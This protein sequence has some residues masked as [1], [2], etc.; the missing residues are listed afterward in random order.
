MRAAERE[1]V[2]REALGIREMMG[3]AARVPNAIHLEI[4][5]PDWDPPAVAREAAV[6]AVHDRMTYTP[7]L[8]IPELRERIAARTAE[9]TGLPVDADMV[10]VTPGAVCAVT[11]LAVLRSGPDRPLLIA[12]PS[13]PNY[14]LTS[15]VAGARLVRYPLAGHLPDVDFL[16][17]LELDDAVL[18]LNSPANPTGAIIDRPLLVRLLELARSRGWFVLV[19]EVYEDLIWEG[20]LARAASVAGS[21]EGLAVVSGVSKS[22]GMTGY[23][24]GWLVT[25]PG[26]T[27]RADQVLETMV[28]CATGSS[29]AAS[30][31][32]LDAAPG[33]LD[34][35]RARLA[36][37]ASAITASCG[38]AGILPYA[39]RGGL[40]AWLS[41]GEE[42]GR[43]RSFA[44]D[45]LAAEGVAVAPGST[46]GPGGEG[47]VRIALVHPPEVLEREAERLV[48]FWSDYR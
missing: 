44:F 2:V 38:G 10:A 30:L 37:R 29:Q 15:A 27:R 31:A 14:A 23:R 18:I 9:R 36:E 6:R 32:A 40:Y 7:S 19:D 41:L 42:V 8:G 26:L 16:E 25:E 39:P 43:S 46:F 13:W 48:R 28:A 20:G 1:S 21:F 3:A 45:L 35:V 24:I 5:Q 34:E 33:Y 4:G 17:G 12:D 22:F 47:H 11:T